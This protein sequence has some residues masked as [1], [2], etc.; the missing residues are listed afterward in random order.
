LTK[1]YFFKNKKKKPRTMPQGVTGGWYSP[2]EGKWELIFD[3]LGQRYRK[4]KKSERE[5]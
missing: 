4:K 5:K 2:K 3:L 1:I